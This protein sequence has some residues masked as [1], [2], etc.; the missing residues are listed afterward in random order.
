MVRPDRDFEAER[1]HVAESFERQRGQNGFPVSLHV[2]DLGHLSKWMLNSWSSTMAATSNLGVFHVGIEVLGIEWTYQ[3]LSI[4]GKSIDPT[5]SGVCWNPPRRH[6]RHVYR[7]T[8]EM[9]ET[10]LG[11]LEISR[12]IETLCKQ[13]NAKGYHFITHNCTD[14]AEAFVG[15]LRASVPFPAWVHGLAKH[16]AWQSGGASS[17]LAKSSWLE[18]C[19][20]SCAAP[21]GS[22][23]SSCGSTEHEEQRH[24][25]IVTPADGPDEFVENA[26]KAMSFGDIES[27]PERPCLP[28]RRDSS[29]AM[30]PLNRRMRRP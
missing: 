12:L 22:Y 27:E 14:F 13:W 19:S 4:K 5:L 1:R 30:Q 3:A 18:A 6:P 16:I 7:E 15:L 8:I 11:V 10:P 23:S 20:I 28:C 26:V 21:C 17:L 24:S 25:L 29:G 9:G 2:Y